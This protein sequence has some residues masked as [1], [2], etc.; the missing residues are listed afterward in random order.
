MRI[1]P[2]RPADLPALMRLYDHARQFMREHGNG[3]QWINGYPSEELIASEIAKG[4]SFACEDDEGEIVGTFCYIEGVDPTYL[5]IEDGQWLND[6]PYATIHRMASSGKTK[7]VA[8]A[9]FQWSFRHCRNIRVDTHRDNLVMQN[10]AH[11][12]GF[13]RCGI[14]HIA[15]GSPRIAYQ[16]VGNEPINE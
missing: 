4:H 10:I 14:I 15:D 1:R 11:K 3:G 12:L 2:S 9:C 7:G 8:D 16:R 6:E 5:K 13:T